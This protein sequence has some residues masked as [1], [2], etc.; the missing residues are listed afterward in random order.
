[1]YNKTCSVCKKGLVV[2]VKY[3][4]R[5][6][7]VRSLVQNH[8]NPSKVEDWTGTWFS[9]FLLI[10]C[11]YPIWRWRQREPMDVSPYSFTGTVPVWYT[12]H[13]GSFLDVRRRVHKQSMGQNVYPGSGTGHL[14]SWKDGP[15][16]LT[17]P[18]S[19]GIIL[20]KKGW[21][22]YQVWS[23]LFM[24]VPSGTRPVCDTC[25]GTPT[26]DV[27]WRSGKPECDSDPPSFP[28]V[29]I[30]VIDLLFRL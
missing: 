27:S 20:R 4:R 22:N 3:W 13:D 14:S 28:V 10:K 25:R 5:I 11:K 30:T 8:R 12:V 19:R 15:S 21:E 17:G 26:S 9:K 1:M 18:N 29:T 24:W 23:K 2:F 16:L 7:K 6:V